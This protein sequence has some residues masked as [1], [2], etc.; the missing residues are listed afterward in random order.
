[1]ANSANIHVININ[2]SI[3]FISPILSPTEMDAGKD[4]LYSYIIKKND[5]M[6]SFFLQFRSDAFFF[7][8]KIKN[9][10]F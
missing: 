2:A 4:P 6:Y 1:M 10:A 8:E 9:K 3:S 7:I 5:P